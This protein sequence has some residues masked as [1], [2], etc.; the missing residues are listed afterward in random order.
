VKYL[1]TFSKIA[2]AALVLTVSAAA[3]PAVTENPQEKDAVAYKAAYNLILD[4]KWEE[5]RKA[6]EDL[7]RNFP[8][9]GWVD[10]A[11]YW[12]C[13][14]LE[15]LNRAQE[16]VFR[17]YQEFIKIYPASQWVNEAQVNMIRIGE[18][19]ARAGKPEYEAII[20]GMRAG[21]EEDV[22]LTALYAL[23]NIGDE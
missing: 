13:Y 7:A 16:E 4:S 17:H 21:Q 23:Q 5:A 20:Q 8:K 14:A 18:A 12:S 22:K 9:S 6:M 10:D 2:M 15:K 11:R 3:F 1:A 19:L